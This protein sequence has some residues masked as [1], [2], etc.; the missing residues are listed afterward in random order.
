MDINPVASLARVEWITTLVL[1]LGCVRR[2][3][4]SWLDLEKKQVW[5]ACGSC[6]CEVTC[7]VLGEVG[8][9]CY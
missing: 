5:G 4:V 8:G 1:A 2:D 7:H 3:A 6:R 9:L